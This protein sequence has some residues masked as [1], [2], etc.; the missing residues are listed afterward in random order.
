MKRAPLLLGALVVLNLLYFT[1]TQGGLAM[2]GAVPA[3]LSEREP[4]RMAQQI[5]PAALQVRKESDVVSPTPVTGASSSEPAPSAAPTVPV[6]PN[7]PSAS[8]ADHEGL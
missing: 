6:A 2:F 8:S 7:A 5:R 1:W 3:S 4:Q